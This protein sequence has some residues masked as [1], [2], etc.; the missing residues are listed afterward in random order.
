MK[1]KIKIEHRD[2]TEIQY[3]MFDQSPALRI[4]IKLMQILSLP[5][6]LPFIFLARLSAESTFRAISQLFSLVPFGIGEIIRYNFYKYTLS[7]LG[8]NVF[9]G[10]GTVLNYRDIRIGSNVQIGMYNIIHHCDFG[11]HVMTAEGCCFLSGSKYHHYSRTDIPMIKQGGQL[12]RIQ[13]GNDVWIGS[14][15]VIMEDIGDGSIVG[16]GSVV[17]KPVEPYTIVAGNPAKELRK[18]V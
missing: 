7:K 14:N 3:W 4:A 10:F 5:F 1:G 12:K 15:S 9:I 6:V 17:T 8:Q 18:R 13:I 16:A 11:N 2:Y